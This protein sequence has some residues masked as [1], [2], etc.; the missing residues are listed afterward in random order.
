MDAAGIELTIVS[1]N[2]PA[3]Q[4]IPEPAK[5]V[6]TAKLWTVILFPIFGYWSSRSRR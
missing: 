6:E 2:A 4:A 1:L 5:A 3:I